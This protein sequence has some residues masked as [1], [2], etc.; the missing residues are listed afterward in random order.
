MQIIDDFLPEDSY[1]DILREI[2]GAY[3]PW[4]YKNYSSSTADNV[5]QFVHVFYVE[6]EVK[7][8]IALGSKL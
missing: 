6:G 1:Q 3:F 5:P 8:Q 2:N 7:I 4:F